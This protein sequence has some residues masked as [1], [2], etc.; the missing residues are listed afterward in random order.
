MSRVSAVYGSKYMAASDPG[1]VGPHRTA[2]IR[3]VQEEAIGFP[4]REMKLV[5]TLGNSAG[6]KWSKPVVLNKGNAVRLAAAFGPPGPGF[7]GDVG[8]RR[9]AYARDIANFAREKKTAAQPCGFGS[10]RI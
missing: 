10:F 5:V 3:G 2:L 1:A 8:L 6:Q 4:D 7:D 9:P